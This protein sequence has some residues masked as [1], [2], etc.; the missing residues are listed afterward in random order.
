MAVGERGESKGGK[1]CVELRETVKFVKTRKHLR[2]GEHGEREV[3][4]CLRAHEKERE[5]VGG[6]REGRRRGW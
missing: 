2:K 6:E 3:T 5:R 1:S 4:T